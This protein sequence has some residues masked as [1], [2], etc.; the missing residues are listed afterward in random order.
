MHPSDAGMSHIQQQHHH[1]PLRQVSSG[2]RSSIQTGDQFSSS[3]SGTT[4]D[5][6]TMDVPN[7]FDFDV[8]DGCEEIGADSR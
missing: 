5:T 8:V 2:P 6:H 1:H 3:T 7:V 4:S